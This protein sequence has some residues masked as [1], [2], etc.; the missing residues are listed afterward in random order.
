MEY[1]DLEKYD[2][3]LP[4][5][6]IRKCGVEPRDSARLFVYDT[7]TD[8]VFHDTFANLASYLP[9]R[10]MLVLNETR[11]VPARLM[12]SKETGGKIEAFVL[13]NEISEAISGTG[14]AESLIPILV[15]RKCVPGMRLFF[16]DGSRFE[17]VSQEENRFFVRLHS[18]KSLSD[19]LDAY[20][21]TPIPHYL[22]DTGTTRDE[23]ALRKRYQTVF[24]RSGASVA[25]PTASLHFTDRVF[26]SLA[27]K[28]VETIHVGLDVGLGTFAS[29]RPENFVSKTLHRERISVS[30][31]AAERLTRAKAEGHRVVAVGTTA[32]R[33]LES[34]IVPGADTGMREFRP[35]SGDTDIFIFPPHRFRSAD[36]LLTNFHLPKSSLMLL[37]EAFL[38]DRG[39]KRTL[40]SLYE[41]AIREGY[42]FYSFG[43]SMLIR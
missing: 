43:D 39:S 42:A 18:G 25:A 36:M 12:L 22:E 31:T 5:G 2:Y 24:A 29:L 16:P 4:K 6:L 40:V 27:A 8:T 23:Q 7:G 10:A 3:R 30:E 35:Y 14:P 37:V 28:G 17:V 41:E 15:D 19:L 32:L 11:V 33:T 13:A 9:E 20:G 21:E 1:R 38:R 34:V 26:G